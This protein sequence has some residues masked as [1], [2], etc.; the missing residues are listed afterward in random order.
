MHSHT[1]DV[2]ESDISPSLC[3]S[4]W[5]T[6]VG[7]SAPMHPRSSLPWLLAASS[8]MPSMPWATRLSSDW[9]RSPLNKA[10]SATSVRTAISLAVRKHNHSSFSSGEARIPLRG[11]LS[12]GQ[13]R[14][15]HGPCRR[16]G[17]YTHP[18]SK[19]RDR[20]NLWQHWSVPSHILRVAPSDRK[21]PTGIGLAMACAIRVPHTTSGL[22]AC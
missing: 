11:R 4:V 13:N 7:P 17:R 10:S 1:Y 14:K 12:Q 2:S 19:C 22:N 9:T 21:K 8:T 3:I 16:E 20:T 6:K 18:R 5:P 15:G